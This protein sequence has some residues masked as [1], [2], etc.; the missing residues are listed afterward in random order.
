MATGMGLGRG[1]EQPATQ[2]KPKLACLAPSSLWAVVVAGCRLLTLVLD[3]QSLVPQEV[4]GSLE[5]STILAWARCAGYTAPHPRGSG[6]QMLVREAR[7]EVLRGGAEYFAR[8]PEQAASEE[9]K[10][11]EC[12][13]SHG[14]L[15]PLGANCG[16]Q[17]GFGA[18]QPLRSYGGN[19]RG[20]RKLLIAAFARFSGVH[21]TRHTQC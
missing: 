16:A 2:P 6:C 1:E 15:W 4:S 13:P 14:G 19:T 20:M 12:A 18:C 5:W 21:N 7:W 3:T 9:R 17:P 10:H 11:G 8:D